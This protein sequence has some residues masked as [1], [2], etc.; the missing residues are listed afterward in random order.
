MCL[1]TL[2]CQVDD[3]YKL[4]EKTWSQR[5]IGATGKRRGPKCALSEPEIIT[6]VIYFHSSGFRTF[7]QYYAHM[8]AH[9]REDFPNL[10]SYSRFVR[11]M[12]RT[13][14]PLYAYL[15]SVQ[16]KCTGIS[17]IDSTSIKVCHNKRISRNKVFKGIARTGKTTSGWFHGFKLHLVVNEK[18]EILSFFLTPA[19]V[20]DT[21]PV[22]RLAKQLY[23]KLFGDKGYISSKLFGKLFHSGVKLVTGIRKRMKPKLMDMYEKLL[24]RK[25][26]IIETINDQLKNISQIEHTRHRSPQNFMVNLLGGLVAYSHQKKKPSINYNLKGLL[27][28]AA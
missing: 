9:H 26:S 18:G 25:R 20:P 6:L 27:V 17:F 22:E 23:G 4:F 8:C 11:V 12:K 10:L 2:Y 21:A 5:L 19:N 14:V 16:G 1:T 24:L 15:I 7:K 13:F 28:A 3:F